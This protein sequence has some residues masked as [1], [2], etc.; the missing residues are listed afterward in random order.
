MNHKLCPIPWMS[1]SLRSNG[2][3]RIC[4]QANQGP[5]LGLLR[6][7]TCLLYTSDAADE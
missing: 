3:I 2:D 7:S 5:D 1:Q 4:C 6:D